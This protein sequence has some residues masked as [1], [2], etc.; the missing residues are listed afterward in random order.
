[1]EQER[2]HSWRRD[3]RLGGR[4][5]PTSSC[6]NHED[7]QRSAA[8]GWLRLCDKS[9]SSRHACY[10]HV[11]IDGIY[12]PASV[13]HN[14]GTVLFRNV[15][16]AEAVFRIERLPAGLVGHPRDSITLGWEERL[17]GRARRRT[18]GGVEF[19]TALPRG[20]MLREGDCLALER[21]PLVIVVH[22]L[23]EPVLV[24]RPS[25]PVEFALWGYHLGNSHQPLMIA[26]DALICADVPGTEQVLT[27]HAIPF[28]REIRPFTP[29]SQAPSHHGEG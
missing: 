13:R 18:D 15:P 10:I 29:V 19:G 23:A 28:L 9:V 2:R 26:D 16:I 7:P 17:K 25:S 27:Y 20:T 22:E 24:A 4:P 12:F 5:H 21:P 3:V 11:D 8:G 6:G 14:S 1:M